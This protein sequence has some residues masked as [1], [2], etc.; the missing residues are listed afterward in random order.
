MSH[1]KSFLKVL[2]NEGYPNPET[3]TYAKLV[4]YD[5]DNFLLD[6]VKEVGLEKADEFVLKALKSLSDGNKGIRVDLSELSEPGDFVYVIIDESRIDFDEFEDTALVNW[7]WG[8]SQITTTKNRKRTI[9]QVWE[10]IGIGEW[11]EMYDFIR[12]I[13]SKLEDIIHK[14]CG[15]HVWFENEV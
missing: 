7:S 15:F 10:D 9:E 8:D 1:I 12:D 13:K 5:L 4:S 3:L 2:Q 11:G 6:L 14:N